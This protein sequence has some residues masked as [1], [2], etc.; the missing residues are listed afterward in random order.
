MSLLMVMAFKFYV[1]HYYT[2]AKWCFL[3]FPGTE[4]SHIVSLLKAGDV[5]YDVFAGVGPFTIPA[6]KKGVLVFAN[7]LNPNS[8]AGLLASLKLNKVRVEP[9]T[10]CMDGR[11]FVT[12]AIKEDLVKRLSAMLDSGVTTASC[13]V[14]MNLPALALEFLD[15]F[16]GLLHGSDISR[17]LQGHSSD[18]NIL[19]SIRW[20][21][22]MVHVYG[23]SKEEN[24]ELE[25]KARAE[26][27]LGVK[28][29]PDSLVR[30]V[31]N[32]APNKDMHCLSFRLPVE[33]AFLDP[34]PVDSESRSDDHVRCS[35]GGGDGVD[36][37]SSGKMEKSSSSDRQDDGPSKRKRHLDISV[38]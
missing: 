28:L 11:A 3:S 16:R 19:E 33:V 12:S 20:A 23:F 31:R 14:V 32:V 8:H 9:T 30:F 25:V 35:S 5:L 36:G 26:G 13:H 18:S 15:A 37:D 22:P 4:H 17:N 29:P 24:P 7:D 38:H 21:L 6:A 34:V 27:S 1:C 10:F 2:V